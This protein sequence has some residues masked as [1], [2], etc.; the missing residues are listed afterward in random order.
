VYALNRRNVTIRNGNVRGFLQAVFLE[1]TSGTFTASQG[2]LVERV[3]ADENTYAGIHVQGR[4]N[5][6]R[7][8]QVVSTTGTTAFGA[9]SEVYGIASEGSG[10]RLID[11]DVTDTIGIGN[12][13]GVALAIA[14]GN[15]AVVEHNRIGNATLV[16]NSVGIR[17]S[18]STSVLAPRNR[19][20]ILSLGIF[21]QG[22]TGLYRGNL[23]SGVTTPYTG[24]TDAGNNQ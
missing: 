4:G 8:N 13:D 12:G 2:H 18:G 15:G 22:S 11:N 24:G 14:S 21:Y 6:V 3:R 16:A 9:D 7:N 19:M 10:A 20:A 1:D 23:T 5:V 17:I